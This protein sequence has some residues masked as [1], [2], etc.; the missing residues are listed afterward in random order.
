MT[1][2][3]IK[4]AD[5]SWQ[6]LPVALPVAEA[7][8]DQERLRAVM[9][10]QAQPT[11]VRL[12]AGRDLAFVQQRAA[13]RR[14]PLFLLALGEARVI[15]MPGELFVE[16]QLAAQEMRPDSF[17]AMAAYGDYGPGYIG[18]SIAYSQ[19][20]YETGPVSRTAPEVEPGSAS[21]PSG[22]VVAEEITTGGESR[23][24][25]KLRKSR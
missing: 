4:A 17:V 18:T 8:R 12:T 21:R 5:V 14:I 3:P 6:S 10:D 7:I 16:Y 13:N 9:I 2:T 24:A 19:G 22:A 20:G 25:T 23:R 1:K 11:R 15:H